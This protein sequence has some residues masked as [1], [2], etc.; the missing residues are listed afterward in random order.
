MAICFV[1]PNSAPCD[2]GD[3]LWF[4]ESIPGGTIPAD[5]GN[6][7]WDTTFDATE[8]AGIEQPGE[9]H[10]TLRMQPTSGGLPVKL[11]PVMMTVLP[12]ATQGLLEGTVTSDR[13]GGPLVADI[14]IESSDGMT[15]TLTTDADGYYQYYLEEGDY[16]VS[17]SSAGY[18]PQTAQVTV[19]GEQTTTQ[20]FVL[21][22]DAANIV[23]DPSSF[24]VTVELGQSTVEIMNISNLGVEALNFEIHERNG[25][26]LPNAAGE[27]ILVVAHDTAAAA[28][29]ES[30]LVTLG[31]TYLE[32]TDAEFQAMTVEQL[33]EYLAVFHAGT[34]GTT[35]APGA[36]ELLLTA[37]LDAGGS[38]FISDNDLGYYRT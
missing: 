18:L 20:D 25:E 37:Y 24:E 28:A 17:A 10:G 36:S 14:L 3:V 2:G 32:V 6:L 27:D 1:F 23:V 29:M 38:L 16:S 7:I 22:R 5:G 15:W 19:V 26:F 33:L 30:A 35:G 4:G 34:T 9:Y 31:Y 8:A 21:V 11:V 12:T 13:P